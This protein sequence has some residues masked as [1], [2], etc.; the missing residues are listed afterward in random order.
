MQMRSQ[1]GM[2]VDNVVSAKVVTAAGEIVE[3]S[4]TS[5]PDLFYAIRG[6]G[7]G[8]YGIVVEWT[9][10]LV[11]Y[12][13]SAMVFMNWTD[14]SVQ[15]NVSQRFLEWAPTAPAEFTSN[16]NIYPDNLQLIGWYLGKSK[17]D[18]EA[19][20]ES[21]GL[22]DL[23]NPQTTIGGDCS[24]DNSRLLGYYIFD[25]VPDDQLTQVKSV[26]NTVPQAFTQI[27]DYPQYAY[28]ETPKN[29]SLSVA[30]PWE[31]Y[32][33]QAKSFFI[34]KDNPLDD[35][36][37]QEV[38]THISKLTAESQGWAEWHAFNL[39]DPNTDSAFA[40]KE[41]ALALLEFQIHGSEDPA[42]QA[43]YDKWMVDLEELLRPAVG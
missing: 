12:P 18:L 39:S 17:Q 25:C 26:L 41:K 35:E 5:N 37:L 28:D 23:G 33:R 3:A 4:Q 19:L 30:P 43:V 9:L 2:G 21:S 1:F 7:G 36:T 14:P 38:I 16:I 15:F 27:D 32:R 11:T 6:G 24:T 40:W 42:K 13:R 29:L 22:L 10:N 8:T 34:Q 31:R 20:M